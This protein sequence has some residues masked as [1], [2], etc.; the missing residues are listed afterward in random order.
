[1]AACRPPI[2]PP[3]LL[4][5]QAQVMGD[6]PPEEL[7]FC[8]HQ[9]V[10]LALAAAGYAFTLVADFPSARL[11]GLRY[12]PIPELPQLPFHAVYLPD[13]RGPSLSRFLTLL[14]AALSAGRAESEEL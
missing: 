7:L 2:A 6:R 13:N 14:T 10:S 4:P 5:L 3:A 1:M 8:D 11:P 12:I 9:E